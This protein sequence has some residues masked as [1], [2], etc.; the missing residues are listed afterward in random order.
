ME[1]TKPKDFNIYYLNF[2][3]VYEIAMM[4]NNV[5]LT[6]IEKD[7]T[8]TFEKQY[9]FT[10]SAS[11][12]GTKQFLDGIKASISAEAKETS[13]SSSKV[14]EILD[15]K[16][17]KSILLRRI[18]ERCIT[19][20]TFAEISEGDLIKIDN[21]NLKLLDEESLRQFLILRRDALKGVRVEGMEL[22]NL[23]SSMLQDYAY[24]LQGTVHNHSNDSANSEIII[25]IPLEIQ[26]EFENKYCIDDLLIGHV[27][28]VGIY[29]GVVDEES[30]TSNTFRYLQEIGIRQKKNLESTTKIIPSSIPP[31]NSSKD[32]E[33]NTNRFHFIDTLAIIQDVAFEFGEETPILHWWNRFGIWLSKL[34]RK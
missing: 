29:K 22:N 33:I 28:I 23:V 10:S 15:V 27:S 7:H 6:K 9:G 34:C 24:I 26:T 17:T 21:V 20:S 13:F 30:I 32:M 25:K 2:S 5:I 16:T 3:K 19:L 31:V 11:A 14:V 18:I 12:Q 4:I 1:K 8:K